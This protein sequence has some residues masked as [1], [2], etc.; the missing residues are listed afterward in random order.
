MQAALKSTIGQEYK[1]VLK[2]R[3]CDTVWSEIKHASRTGRV[4][5]SQVKIL[6]EDKALADAEVLE[7]A[8]TAYWS[9]SQKDDYQHITYLKP[10]KVGLLTDLHLI[11]HPESFMKG[12]FLP[13]FNDYSHT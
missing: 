5:I 9:L 6:Q 12:T 1:S 13:D 3:V 10:A 8:L 11:P 4:L 2:R 7:T